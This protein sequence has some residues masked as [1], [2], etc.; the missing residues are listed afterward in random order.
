MILIVYFLDICEIG[1]SSLGICELSG[2]S[3][4]TLNDVR[5][6][7]VEMGKCYK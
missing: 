4:P 3:K 6:A 2:R 7:L 5:L 1:R